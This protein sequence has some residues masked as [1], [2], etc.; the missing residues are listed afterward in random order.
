M[1]TF[2]G[3][4][5]VEKVHEKGDELFGVH[6]DFWYASSSIIQEHLMCKGYGLS[7]ASALQF[8]LGRH[9]ATVESHHGFTQ[10]LTDL[11]QDLGVIVM[12]N[13]L[14]NGLC[15]LGR[16]PRL[17][18]TG[19]HKDAIAAQLHHQGCIGRRGD[20]TSSKVDDRQST[21]SSRFL[22]QIVWSLNI[23][24]QNAQLLVGHGLCSL[25]L[26]RDST[27]VTDGLDNISRAGLA[28]GAD[29]GS[30]FA[31]AT[32]SL[33]EIFAATDKGNG[34]GV[35]LDVMSMVSRGQYF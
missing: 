11:G 31:D 3:N 26:S 33:A 8:V 19:T 4:H 1:E 21:Q 20:A 2:R 7:P 5:G 12:G 22:D 13:G 25:D 27:H 28:L 17:E 34:E 10:I 14:Y 16:I 35:L 24:G 30:T 15:S 6:G 23:F 32:E 18:D 29:H 9:G